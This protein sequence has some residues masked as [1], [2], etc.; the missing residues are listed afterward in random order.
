MP[1]SNDTRSDVIDAGR[2]V[3]AGATACWLGMA[4]VLGALVAYGPVP[5]QYGIA[6]IIGTF[7]VILSADVWVQHIDVDLE[8]E[9]IDLVRDGEDPE[10]VADGGSVS[11][12]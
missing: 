11:D 2:T 6:G 1:L 7:L 4:V 3:S 9:Y 12:E 10:T 8:R 5:W